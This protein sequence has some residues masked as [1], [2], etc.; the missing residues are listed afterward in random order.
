MTMTKAVIFDMD[1][2][3]LDTLGDLAAAVNYAL[4]QHGYP[5]R[6]VAQVRSYLGNGPANLIMQ[7]CPPDT[8]PE[9][10]QAVLATY[11]P[12]YA[13]HCRE[14]T[15]P[16]EG[17]PAL[18]TE[19]KAAGVA[20]AVVSNKQECDVEAL[21]QTYF[22]DTI[23]VA[24]GGA[25][26]RPLKPDPTGLYLALERLGVAKE[27]AW[28]VGDSEV[29]VTTAKN[30]GMRCIAVSWGFRDTPD[31]LAAGADIIVDKPMDAAKYIRGE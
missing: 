13:A 5:A 31:L 24:V 16:Y 27:D 12:Y 6:T 18:L 4:A 21:R 22:A 14:R 8:P 20:L 30:A 2:T 10:V 15:A 29:D 1:G 17:I 19:L 28:F 7:S 11:L 25:E 9:R 3:I 26:G 23:S